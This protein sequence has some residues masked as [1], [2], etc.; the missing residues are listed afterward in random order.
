MTGDG[1]ITEL[2]GFIV[3]NDVTKSFENFNY[4]F[5]ISAKR[6]GTTIQFDTSAFRERVWMLND[7][8]RKRPNPKTLGSFQVPTI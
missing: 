5:E 2:S 1:R 6:V 4:L 3:Y 7:K 8:F